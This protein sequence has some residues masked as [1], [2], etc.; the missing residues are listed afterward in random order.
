MARWVSDQYRETVSFA[1][2]LPSHANHRLALLNVAHAADGDD[3]CDVSGGMEAVEM[4]IT[5]VH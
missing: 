3:A 4:A 1:S 2:H 5:C